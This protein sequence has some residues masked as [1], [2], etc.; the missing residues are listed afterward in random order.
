MVLPCGRAYREFTLQL[1]ARQNV[2][3]RPEADLEQ[4]AM[5]VA[6]ATV[7]VVFLGLALA[8]AAAVICYRQ[9]PEGYLLYTPA[10]GVPAN[11]TPAF[12]LGFALVTFIFTVLSG[13]TTVI[14]GVLGLAGIRRAW[15][16]AKVAGLS[17]LTFGACLAVGF[18][19]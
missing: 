8:V 13:L 7:I 3:F 18:W 15:P 16:I 2:R 6:R 12:A 14:A 10:P 19:F 1:S 9:S 5:S 4:E 17:A 11:Y